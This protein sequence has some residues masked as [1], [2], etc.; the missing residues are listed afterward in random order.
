MFTIYTFFGLC[1][2]LLCLLMFTALDMIREVYLLSIGNFGDGNTSTVLIITIFLSH[3]CIYTPLN[4]MYPPPS[5]KSS[6][7][8]LVQSAGRSGLSHLTL[9]AAGE[10]H[11]QRRL[12]VYHCLNQFISRPLV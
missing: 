8:V 5:F 6:D 7:N 9:L 12:L 4:Y 10:N 1:I 11:P 2:F 3:I